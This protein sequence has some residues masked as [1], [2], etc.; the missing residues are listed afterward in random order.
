MAKGKV[1]YNFDMQEF[2]SEEAP[3]I[4]V[5][6]KDKNGDVFHTYSSY[7]RGTETSVGTYNF[8]DLVPKGRDEDT[9]AFTMAWVRHHDRYTD[10]HLADAT[11]P[12]WPAQAEGRNV[13]KYQNPLQLRSGRH[14]RRG[15]RCFAPV[16]KKNQ[17]FPQTVQGQ[18]SAIPRRRRRNRQR[19][20]PS[21]PFARNERTNEES[22]RRGRNSEGSRCG[23]IRY[24]FTW[25]RPSASKISLKRRGWKTRRSVGAPEAG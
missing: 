3:G 14:G 8:L 6:Y 22:K 12:Y 10:G 20:L 25:R 4:S 13:Q 24:G 17:R 7:A 23:E 16:H 18:R 21:S 1:Y 2:P 15:S 9:L 5:F 11:R 19:L